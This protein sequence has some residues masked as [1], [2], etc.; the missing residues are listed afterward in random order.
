MT[1]IKW[2]EIPIIDM[3]REIYIYAYK[4]YKKTCCIK[5]LTG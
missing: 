4:N 5:R 3:K 1:F 2:I